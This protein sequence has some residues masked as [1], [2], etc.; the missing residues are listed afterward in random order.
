MKTLTAIVIALWSSA[1]IGNAQASLPLTNDVPIVDYGVRMALCDDFFDHNFSKPLADVSD[2]H[3]EKE[4]TWILHNPA[5]GIQSVIF[6]GVSNSFDFRLFSTSGAEIPKTSKG[7]AMN[8]GPKSLTTIRGNPN[9]NRIGEGA[10]PG[11]YAPMVFPALL[12]DLFRFPSNG[13]Y[14]LEV[15]YWGWSPTKQRFVLSE[16]VR[17]RVVKSDTKEIPATSK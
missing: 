15:R 10:P 3:A 13:I 6:I 16:P 12:N 1:V 11:G 9:A 17:L 14:I 5:P 7:N 2:L 8:V 4:L